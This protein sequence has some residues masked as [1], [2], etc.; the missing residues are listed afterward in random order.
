[1]GEP[2]VTALTGMVPEP[3]HALGMIAAAISPHKTPEFKPC[4]HP[5]FWEYA[6]V[7]LV[8]FDAIHLPDLGFFSAD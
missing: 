7:A 2:R 6:G 8:R 5:V 1:M 3:R 4:F